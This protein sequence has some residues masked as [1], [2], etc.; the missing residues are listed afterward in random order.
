VPKRK[1]KY[2]GCDLPTAGR[3]N[4]R[5]IHLLDDE[6]VIEAPVKGGFNYKSP[7]VAKFLVT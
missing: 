4:E 5:V 1:L 2:T 7:K 6:P 3:L